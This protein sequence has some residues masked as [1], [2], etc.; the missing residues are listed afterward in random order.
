M[1][2]VAIEVTKFEIDNDG[3]NFVLYG[4][5]GPVSKH[6]I[7]VGKRVVTW[8]KKFAHKKTGALRASIEMSRA[9]T[10]PR[11]YNVWVTASSRHAL[12]H[13]E[14]ARAHKITAR[15]GG[16]LSFKGK[17]GTV[18]TKSV[19]H[20]GSAANPYLVKALVKVLAR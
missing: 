18:T 8:S 11:G 9:T 5:G 14:G 12:V 10:G 4:D 17:G 6:M 19:N 20:P 1:F 3:L 2:G 7:K 16:V 15:K 13:H